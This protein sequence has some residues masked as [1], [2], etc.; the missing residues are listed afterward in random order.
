MSKPLTIRD[1]EE[2]SRMSNVKKHLRVYYYL[3]RIVYMSVFLKEG[4]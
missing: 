4:V 1:D 2:N 3:F